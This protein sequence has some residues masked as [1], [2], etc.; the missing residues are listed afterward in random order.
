MVSVEQRI[1]HEKLFERAARIKRATLEKIDNLFFPIKKE[2][3]E[4]ENIESLKKI[5]LGTGIVEKLEE[6]KNSKEVIYAKTEKG[7]RTET[8]LIHIAYKENEEEKQEIE[9]IFDHKQHQGTQRNYEFYR[10]ILIKTWSVWID[11]IND[12]K[13]VFFSL[14]YE[15]TRHRE[16]NFG[17]HSNKYEEIIEN[18]DR[19]I[20]LRNKQEKKRTI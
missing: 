14:E 13:T 11:Q 17:I 8:E 10:K 19:A 2:P 20:N 9:V 12:K 4:P 15:D 18:I 3:E 5:W 7:R 16:D 6:I 1:N